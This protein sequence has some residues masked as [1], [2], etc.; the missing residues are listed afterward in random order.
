MNSDGKINIMKLSIT[1]VCRYILLFLLIALIGWTFETVSCYIQFG[2][3][4]ER[5]FLNLPLCPIYGFLLIG[6][7]LLFGTP[8]EGGMILKRCGKGIKRLIAYYFLSGFLAC[9]AELATGLFFENVY[10]VVL[11]DYSWHCFDF[12]KYIS[13][14]MGLVWGLLATV[15]MGLLF[16]LLLKLIHKIPEKATRIVATVLGSVFLL[17]CLICF[18]GM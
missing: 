12:M 17:D 5:G 9:S 8:V 2:F 13:L 16:P 7:Y 4:L 6:M 1:V 11:W 14:E 18:L 10:G 3:L 15:I